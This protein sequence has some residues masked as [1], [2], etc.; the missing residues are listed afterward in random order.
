MGKIREGNVFPI[1]FSYTEVEDI[2][3]EVVSVKEDGE[4]SVVI[5]ECNYMTAPISNLRA[6]DII[7]NTASYEGLRISS[8]AVRVDSDGNIGVFVIEGQEIGFKKIEV[9]YEDTDYV[10]VSTENTDSDYIRVFDEV[11]LE[12]SD[13]YDGKLV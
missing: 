13:L 8:K 6:E 3:A 10:I 5:F 2:P 9:L 7:I 12:G 1:S 11:I 4:N